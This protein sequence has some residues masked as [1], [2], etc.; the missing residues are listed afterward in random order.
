MEQQ[1][2]P[3]L[4]EGSN[5]NSATEE[6]TVLLKQGSASA[7]EEDCMVPIV[8][9]PASATHKKARHDPDTMDIDSSEAAIET[10]ISL[11]STMEIPVSDRDIV[12]GLRPV[13]LQIE[14]HNDSASLCSWLKTLDFLQL[15]SSI[16]ELET[17]DEILEKLGQIYVAARGREAEKIETHGAAVK[18]QICETA[19]EIRNAILHTS[20]EDLGTEMKLFQGL[21]PDVQNPGEMTR[22]VIRPEDQTF[23]DRCIELSLLHHPVCGVGNPGIGRTT[24]TL[25]LLQQ[26]VMIQKAPVVYTIRKAAGLDVFYEFV[27]EMDSENGQVNDISVK[28]YK[29]V[30]TSKDSIIP[31]MEENGAFYVVDPGKFQG[32]CDDTDD[33]YEARFI[34]A[35]SNDNRHWGANEFTK[36]REPSSQVSLSA[37]LEPNYALQIGTLLG[38]PVSSS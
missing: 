6:A 34:M 10:S 37:S 12:M 30:A 4:P 11:I 26:L 19:I 20:L 14:V 31:S 13:V 32:S 36:S 27:P 22:V 15:D 8:V 35:A 3:K 25:Y 7:K 23:W 18:L 1:P 24:T 29:I 28:L 17:K 33:L 16:I 9:D 21:V 5:S 38:C 2:K